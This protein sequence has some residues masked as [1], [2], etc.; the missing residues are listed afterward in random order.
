MKK[1]VV[2]QIHIAAMMETAVKMKSRVAATS[3]VVSLRVTRVVAQVKRKH[4]ATK[5]Q[6]RAVMEGTVVS[7]LALHPLIVSDVS[8]TLSLR[9]PMMLPDW[10]RVWKS[11]R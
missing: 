4:V 11:W 2:N 3:S 5:I 1:H 10:N 7:S 9:N 6:K 8:L